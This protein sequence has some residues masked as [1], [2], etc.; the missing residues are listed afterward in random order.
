MKWVRDFEAKI[1]NFLYQSHL[2]ASSG[3]GLF[4]KK[5]V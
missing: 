1:F 2:P 5:R 3:Y 4:E